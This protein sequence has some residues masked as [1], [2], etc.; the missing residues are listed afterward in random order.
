MLKKDGKSLQLVHDLQ[1]LNTISVPDAAVPLK[2]DELTESFAGRACYTVF[3]LL[4]A[5]DQQALD[6]HSRNFTMFQ[7]P[8]GTF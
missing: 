1:P 8:L 5:F 3:N 7:T 4:V 6:P 2:I